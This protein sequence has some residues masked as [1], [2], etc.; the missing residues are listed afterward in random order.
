MMNSRYKQ[1]LM[2]LLL[3]GVSSVSIVESFSISTTSHASKKHP[4][5]SLTA[6]QI[7]INDDGE[8]DIKSKEQECGIQ[9]RRSMIQS[10]SSIFFLAT[11]K[12]FVPP[13]HAEE[14]EAN[15]SSSSTT[16][17][18]TS[19]A[20]KK[21][22]LRGTVSLQPGVENETG[23]ESALYVT[24]R[25]DRPDNVP[26]AIL[27]GSRGK[28]PPVLAARFPNPT[29]PFDLS[30]TASDLTA[31]GVSNV[32]GDVV[33]SS[34]FWWG[35]D[36]LVV[37]ARL[38]SDGVASTRDPTDLVGRGFFKRGGKGDGFVVQLQGRGIGGKFVTGAKK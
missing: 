13:S 9:T 38:D 4:L 30:L 32:D 28:A 36:D 14:E 1:H 26:K 24:V 19:A 11:L 35:G 10:T 15:S 16:T 12:S 17:T 37:S 20:G 7:N 22:L 18:T 21:E 2:Y 6:S 31:E 25:P 8:S 3:I 34:T 33:E 5:V 29:F 27:D 23:P